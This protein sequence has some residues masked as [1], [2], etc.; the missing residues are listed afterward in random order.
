[1]YANLFFDLRGLSTD[2]IAWIQLLSELMGKLPTEKYTFGDLENALNSKTGDFNTSFSWFIKDR[3]DDQL[4]PKFKV[5]SKAMGDKTQ[6]MFELMTEVVTKTKYND[7]DRLKEL[8]TR[9]QADVDLRMKQNGLGVARNRLFSYFSNEGV[10]QEK[11]GGLEYYRFITDLSKNF[12]A[13]KEQ[14]AQKLSETASAIFNNVNLVAATT[15]SDEDYVSFEKALATLTNA[16]P[17]TDVTMANWTF[18]KKKSNEGIQ[19]ASKVQYVLQ[20]ADYKKLGYQ[21]NG[22]LQVLEQLLSTDYLQTQVRV[23]GGAYGGFIWFSPSGGMF[24]GSYRDPNLKETLDNYKA[25]PAYLDS[26]KLDE[27]ALTRFIIGTIAN[28]DQPMTPSQK[29]ERAFT[30]Y[31]SG[32]TK[33][34]KQTERDEILSTTL[35]DLKAFKPMIEGILEQNTYCVYGN[36]EKLKS[37]QNLF[38][39]LV[40]LSF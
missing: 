6:E 19:T 23:I 3:S 30:Y 36:D 14:I 40:K 34:L 26:L 22:H 8:I 11:K 18:E 5:S 39:S 21:W 20:G 4:L 13:R 37:N 7:L 16:L 31:F 1:M 15:C 33:Q 12:D 17:T 24:F 25:T 38:D 10:L 9:H 32:T 35:D 28:I 2:E 29:G 27:K